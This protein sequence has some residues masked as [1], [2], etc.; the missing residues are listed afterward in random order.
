MHGSMNADLNLASTLQLPRARPASAC[1]SWINWTSLGCM[2]AVLFFAREQ[3]WT[4]LPTL[5]GA[6]LGFAVPFVMLE[7]LTQPQIKPIVVSKGRLERTLVRTLGI[8]AVLAAILFLFWLFPYTRDKYWL[9]VVATT[10]VATLLMIASAFAAATPAYL[11]LADAGPEPQTDGAYAFG[12]TLLGRA[13]PVHADA[14]KQF[15]LG[16][17]VKAFFLPLMF[18][19]MI[20]DMEWFLKVNFDQ[21]FTNFTTSFEFL[22][23]FSYMIDV[24]IA[25][26]G[27]MLTMRLLNTHIRSTDPSGWGWIVCLFC[28][29]PFWT[30]LY[31]NFATYDDAFTW[32]VWLNVEVS[33]ARM[34][35]GSTIL[36]FS[37]VYVWATIQ[38]GLRFSN[39][40]HR[41]II[42]NGPYRW[43]KHPAYI[44]KNISWWMISV[45]FLGNATLEG[46][47]RMCLLLGVINLI[48]YWRAKCEERHLMAD[49]VYRDYAAWID[50]HGLI[51]KLRRIGGR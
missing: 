17:G 15:M 10:P 32:G 42:T 44:C 7:R 11:W 29:P 23:R 45:P 31:Q 30:A 26:G 28:Y 16:W 40:T 14:R 8:Y 3:F 1:V 6:V 24:G 20:A 35:W 48:Y 36:A 51:A 50:Q 47:I 25:V 33:F 21:A 39:L 27:Y 46:A 37:F 9:P 18:S 34:A 2:L 43:S 22:L 5:I 13:T 41:G 4:P 19:I 38:F 49:P 12:L